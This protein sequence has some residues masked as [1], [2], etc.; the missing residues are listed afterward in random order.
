MDEKKCNLCKLR[1]AC[2]HFSAPFCP[3]LF[4]IVILAVLML[5][6]YLIWKSHSLLN[7]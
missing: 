5:P 6:A 4:Y 3:L 7:F 2:K 1:S